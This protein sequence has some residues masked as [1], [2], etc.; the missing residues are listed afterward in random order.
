MT[1]KF[2]ITPLF[3]IP[4]Y[5]SLV[6]NVQ[7][8]DIEYIKN[9]KYVRYPSDDGYGTSDKFILEDPHL[10]NLKENILKRC[11]HF[12]YDILG[13][14]NEVVFE[15]TNSWG[16]RHKKGDSSGG[17]THKN[18]MVSGVFYAQTDNMSGD[19]MFHKEK[20]NYN[21]FTPTVSVPFDNDNL[22][23]F[24]TEGW[25]IKPRNNMLIL[26]PSTLTHSVFENKSEQ[27]RYSIAF[28][29]FSFGKFGFDNVT[30]LGLSNTTQA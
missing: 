3:G 9:L 21:I 8:Q 23:I 29:L 7:T 16:N 14:S 4:L 5:Q 19:I 17:H 30:Q 25:A 2:N 18:S 1:D 24:N 28:N 15:I 11:R 12:L 27:E 20:T 10:I 6:E 22:N 13:V 26:F